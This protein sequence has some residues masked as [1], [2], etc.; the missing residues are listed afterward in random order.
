MK[1]NAYSV[2]VKIL[3]CF[4]YGREEILIDI[5]LSIDEWETTEHSQ[6]FT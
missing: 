3:S 6:L 4:E 2:Y 1:Q 5:K